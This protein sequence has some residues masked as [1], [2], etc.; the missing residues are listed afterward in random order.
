QICRRL[1]HDNVLARE[2]GSRGKVVNRLTGAAPAAA[3]R[4]TAHEAVHGPVRPLLEG[5][6]FMPRDL[7]KALIVIPCSK[8]KQNDDGIGEH[9]APITA[10]LPAEF[11]RELEEA[12]AR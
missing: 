8:T 7:A 12:R 5:V 6:S 9:G 4:L 11:A 3:A 10:S 2:R 1:E